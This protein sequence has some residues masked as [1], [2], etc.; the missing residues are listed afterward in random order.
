MELAEN[1]VVGLAVLLIAGVSLFL[2][3]G[4][5]KAAVWLHDRNLKRRE[6]GD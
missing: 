6:D 3:A 1:V 4:V 5:L 2:V